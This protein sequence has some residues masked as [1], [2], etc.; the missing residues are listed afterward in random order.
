MVAEDI[1]FIKLWASNARDMVAL[2]DLG[3]DL[4]DLP[5]MII[6]KLV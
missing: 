3:K 2:F 5:K 4:K 1:A 6:D